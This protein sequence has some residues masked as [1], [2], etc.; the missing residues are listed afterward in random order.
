MKGIVGGNTGTIIHPP[1][2]AKKRFYKRL[3]EAKLRIEKA[4]AKRL[5]TLG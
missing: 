2:W 3:R 4:K 1:S 5:R